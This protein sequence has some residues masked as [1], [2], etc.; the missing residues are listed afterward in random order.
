VRYSVF[1][2]AV[3]VEGFTVDEVPLLKAKVFSVMESA[4]IQYGA[5]WIKKEH[6]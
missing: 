6:E 4:L 5:S 2:P 3:N 1:L